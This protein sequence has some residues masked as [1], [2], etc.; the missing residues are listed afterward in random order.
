MGRRGKVY[1][2]TDSNGLAC[3]VGYW[4]FNDGKASFKGTFKDGRIH[5]YGIYE[6]VADSQEGEW[7]EGEPHGN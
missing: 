3:G 5:G 1:G 7:R 2:E 4:K 6:T